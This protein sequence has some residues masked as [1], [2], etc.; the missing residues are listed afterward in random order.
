MKAIELRTLGGPPA[1]KHYF[2]M[3]DKHRAALGDVSQSPV[4]VKFDR[5][6]EPWA[7]DAHET[8]VVYEVWQL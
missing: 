5:W 8:A 4:E 6:C 1:R 3:S 2:V 7:D